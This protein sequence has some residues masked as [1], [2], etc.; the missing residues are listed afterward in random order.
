MKS[1]FFLVSLIVACV[2]DIPLYAQDWDTTTTKFWQTNG[3]ER[4]EI[5]S[6]KDQTLQPSVYRKTTS[7]APQPLLVY[8]HSWTADYQQIDSMALIAKERDWN[9]IAPNFRGP[10]WNPQSA[11][12][13]YVIPDIDDAIVWMLANAKVAPKEVHLYGRSAGGHAV[14]LAYM[15][16]KYPAKTFSS[17]VGISNFAEWHYETGTRKLPQHKQLMIAT[18]DTTKPNIEEMKRRSPIF[19]PVPKNRTGAKL[20]LYSGIH[21]GYVGSVPV[22]QSIDF[23]NHLVRAQFPKTASAIV[24]EK[25]IIELLT[26]RTFER[27]RTAPPEYIDGRL[28]HYK[29]QQGN[30]SVTIFEGGHEMFINTVLAT[31][32]AR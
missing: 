5:R 19:Q 10:G 23:Y 32:L 27:R 28:V 21:D 30:L 25:D 13:E 8:L 3:F 26:K 9:Y 15:N 22:T 12:S 16:L 24:P 7:N 4:A 17:W 6:S 1:F 18:G 14:M 20:F 31:I 29:K 11:G 2:V